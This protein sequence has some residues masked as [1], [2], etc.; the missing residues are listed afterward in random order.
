ML[1][2]DYDSTR[3]TDAWHPLKHS[4]DNVKR[5][6]S[7]LSLSILRH[8]PRTFSKLRRRQLLYSSQLRPQPH[9]NRPAATVTT[10]Q[11]SQRQLRPEIDHFIFKLFLTIRTRT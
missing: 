1:D 9:W 7:H 11:A 4:P 10:L 8:F 3:R 6:L 2:K 5:Q